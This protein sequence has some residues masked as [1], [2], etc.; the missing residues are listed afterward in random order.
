MKHTNIL[1]ITLAVI[2]L[3]G[4]CAQKEQKAVEDIVAEYPENTKVVFE[5]DYVQA[6]E[7]T[8]K[9]GE[10][11][12]LHTGGP[13]VVYA[14]A[15]YKIKWTE[16][17]KITEKEW[18]KGDT[19]WHSAIDHAV[20]NI[21]DVDAKYLVVTRTKNPL[22]ETGENDLSRDASQLDSEHSQIIFENDQVRVIE[23]N[24]PGGES[25]PKH[26]GINRLIYSL[27]DYQIEYT[28][29]QLNNVET[30]MQAGYIHWHAPEKHAVKN[31]GDT[32]AHYLIFAFKQ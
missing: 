11:L 17:G 5:N 32:P 22:P 4:A 20:E 1:I 10:K 30:E 13:R 15:D 25:Q 14:L 21:G 26:D 18:K 31:I 3:V 6:V 24:L 19:H 7:F 8:L 2:F 29:Y 12:P 23:V 28:Y 16:G 27:N 9:P